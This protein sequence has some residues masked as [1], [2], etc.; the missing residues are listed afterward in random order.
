MGKVGTLEAQRR[1][2][3][4]ERAWACRVFVLGSSFPFHCSLWV[5]T[6]RDGTGNLVLVCL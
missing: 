2:E 3:A 4:A 5:L 1:E 6:L